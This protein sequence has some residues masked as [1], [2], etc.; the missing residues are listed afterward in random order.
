MLRRNFI[1]VIGCATIAWPWI[2]LARRSSGKVWRVAYLFLGAL[3]PDRALFDAFRAVMRELGYI[4]GKN[5]VIKIRKA[6]GKTNR[7]PTPAKQ[8][9]A[10]GRTSVLQ[11]RT[12]PW[13]PPNTQPLPFPS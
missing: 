3:S 1:S 8:L 9:I 5:L 13:L 2:A 7:L 4:E 10:L 11:T 12:R 6:E